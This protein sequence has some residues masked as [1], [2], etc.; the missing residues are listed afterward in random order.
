MP[1][2][3]VFYSTFAISHY[4]DDSS[5][6]PWVQQKGISCNF[7]GRKAKAWERSCSDTTLICEWRDMDL[8]LKEHL[9]SLEDPNLM[10]DICTDWVRHKDVTCLNKKSQRW[11]KAY[12]RACTIGNIKDQLCSDKGPK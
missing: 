6:S 9:C 10:E 1:I 2:A 7:A 3:I 5:C 11:E 12:K 8:C 4:I